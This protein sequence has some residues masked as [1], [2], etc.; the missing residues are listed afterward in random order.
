MNIQ[1]RHE[2]QQPA[3]DETIIHCQQS[4]NPAIHDQSVGAGKTIQIAFFAKHVADKGGRVLVLAR[5]GELIEQ[6]SDDY[7]MIGGK[8]SIYSASLGMRSTYYPVI[9]GT[10]GTIGRE[11]EGDF[12]T[13]AFNAILI[14]ECHHV[15]W[16]DALLDEPE[17]QYGKII[18]H[19]KTLNP[20]TRIV[21]YTGS[22]YRGVTDIIGKFWTK[23]LS[24]VGTYQLINLGYLVP[25]VFGFGDDQHSYDLSEWKPKGGEGAQEFTQKELQAMGRKITKDQTKTQIIM[26]EVIARTQ[27][28]NGV[29]ITCASKNHCEQ[30]ADCLPH[31]SWG[32][33][34]DSTSTK[35]RR[36]LLSKAKKG[37]LKYMLQIGCLTTG[38]NVPLWDTCVILRKIGSLTLLIQLIGRVL[39]T[40]KQHQIDDGFAKNDALV[41][42]YTDTMES[43]GDI[44]DDP[45]LKK[46]LAT[47]ATQEGEHVSCPKCGT[48]NSMYAVRCIGHDDNEPDGR[49]GFYFKYTECGVCETHNAPTARNCRSCEA[50]LIDPNKA[51]INKAYT[52]ADYKPV[53]NMMFST[54]QTQ[55]LCVVYQLAT[56]YHDKGIEKPEVAKEYFAVDSKEQHEKARWS[57]FIRQHIQ[58]YKF[59]QSM[60]KNKQLGLVIKNKSMFDS[61]VE[62]THRKNDKG[63]S[64]INRK[65]FRS[66]REAFAK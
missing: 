59:Q 1:L 25:P 23:K 40:L 39:R 66:G 38:V 53:V 43:M 27:D 64:I 44:Y 8:C 57:N 29:L 58:G 32:I 47:K 55:K 48:Q 17:T 62:I 28:R 16:Q 42:D 4:I 34:T 37:E 46:A 31:G 26:E 49:C 45:I 7:K 18:K 60:L 61:P 36:E 22:P 6:N 30:V 13:L 9:F 50:V 33:I 11:L 24:E 12:K 21:G 3:H 10:E 15:D 35:K 5:Q 54:T 63:F 41:L 51:L 19:F 65:R 14:D 52:D 2:Y 56:T 20:K